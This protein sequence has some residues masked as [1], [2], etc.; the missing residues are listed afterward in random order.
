MALLLEVCVVLTARKI[1]VL[2]WTTYIL[3]SG[4]LMLL[5]PDNVHGNCSVVKQ[6]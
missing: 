6:L 5:H 2:F 4:A 3:F 1:I